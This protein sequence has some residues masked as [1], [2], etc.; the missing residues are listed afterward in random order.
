MLKSVALHH[1]IVHSCME[2]NLST[3]V[4]VIVVPKMVFLSSKTH[5]TG[6]M[7][8]DLPIHNSCLYTIRHCMY[9][10]SKL[11]PIT[12]VC[13]CLLNHRCFQIDVGIV[14]RYSMHF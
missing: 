10:L 1:I 11:S 14:T 9:S 3:K 2:F 13:T 12:S 7:H 4:Q 6:N 5:S 8:N